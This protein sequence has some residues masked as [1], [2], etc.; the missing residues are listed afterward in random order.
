MEYTANIG[1]GII[2]P[3]TKIDIYK[4]EQEISR[5]Y[6]QREDI[7]ENHRIEMRKLNKEFYKLIPSIKILFCTTI[8]TIFIYSLQIILQM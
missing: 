1:I 5:L 8:I 6:K 2:K 3:S 7:Y 4:Y